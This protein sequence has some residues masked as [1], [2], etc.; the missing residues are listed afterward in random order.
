MIK[1]GLV[2]P[3][4][5]VPFVIEYESNNGRPESG[6]LPS[7]YKDNSDFVEQKLLEHGAILFRG[8][9]IN[10]PGSFAR[11]TRSIAP[12]LA[13][14]LD[15]NGPRTKI[16]SGI[17][18]STEYPAEYQLSM[19]SE[20]AY[21]HKFPARLYFCCV[22]EPGQ[23]GATPL[24]D[25]RR[26]LKKLDPAI[27]E[28]FK[29]KRIKYVRNL[30]A[31]SGFGLSWQAAFQTTDRS[32]VEK[33]CQDMSIDYEWKADGGLRLEN[34]FDSVITHPRT[35]EEVWFNQA[36]QFHPSDYPKHI[37]ESLLDSYRGNEHELPQTSFFGDDSPIDVDSLKHI[38]ETMFSEATVNPWR[39]GDVVMIDNVLV[40]HGRMPYSGP[41]KILLAMS[42]N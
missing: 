38:R 20:Y 31:S 32:V 6:L 10:T 22:V 12:G 3:E 29:T 19:H 4:R 26:I 41:R 28:E 34:T 30:H 40:C 27:V 2:D 42:N 35:G 13:D 8:F 33:Y 39:Q 1:T 9:D 37:F 14:C 25:N 5:S 15:D 21:S 11:L 24:A 18:T 17:Y 16:T 23:G 36:P 7:W